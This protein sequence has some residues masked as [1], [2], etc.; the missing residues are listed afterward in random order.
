MKIK[1]AVARFDTLYPNAFSHSEKLMWLSELDGRIYSEILSHYEN[2]P[3]FF[4]GYSASTSE[5]TELLVPFP[6]DDIYIKFMCL[7]ADLINSD[8][9]R[10][11]NSAMLFNSAFTSLANA[12]NRTHTYKDKNRIT[13]GGDKNAVSCPLCS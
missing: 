3:A 5:S 13:F 10:F 11:N 4:D 12:Y 8:I 6:D 9:K 7:K 2:A 1:E